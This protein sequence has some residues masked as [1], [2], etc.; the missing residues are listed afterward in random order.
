MK[1]PNGGTLITAGSE[2]D[3]V[4]GVNGTAFASLD[5]T[6]PATTAER[7]LFPTR[8]LGGTTDERTI[9]GPVYFYWNRIEVPARV[10]G[11]STNVLIGMGGK[12]LREH[13]IGLGVTDGE[14]S[15]TGQDIEQLKLHIQSIVRLQSGPPMLMVRTSSGF[16]DVNPVTGAYLSVGGASLPTGTLGGYFDNLKAIRTR[17]L[18]AWTG[19]GYDPRNL[20]MHIARSHAGDIYDKATRGFHV[21]AMDFS[22]T[23]DNCSA[24]DTVDAANQAR[25]VARS[26]GS[27]DE[28][29]TKLGYEQ[30]SLIEVNS[31]LS[32]ASRLN[33]RGRVRSRGVPA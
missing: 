15:R 11:W 12:A 31:C 22:A 18:L 28:H 20:F 23:Y 3:P 33:L 9:G 8:W 7:R 4:T 25:I 17:L 6:T 14:T 5:Y 24:Y 26:W 27:G 13:A 19:L 32:E 2:T 30:Q 29:M 1:N 16:N 10:A 21:A